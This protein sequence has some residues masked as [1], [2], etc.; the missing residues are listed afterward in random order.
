M[1]TTNLIVEFLVIGIQ[2]AVWISLLIL[3][4][5]GTNWLEFG[6]VKEFSTIIVG[7]LIAI[8]YPIGVFVDNF[9]DRILKKKD[10]KI[11]NEFIK[12]ENKSILRV[13]TLAGENSPLDQLFN[14]QRMRIRISRSSFLNFL[15]ISL[16]LPIFFI[17]QLPKY[18]G[19]NLVWVCL[20]TSAIG[21]GF[22]YL[23]YW[24]WK[25]V[26]KRYYRRYP[27]AE[28]LLKERGLLK[29]SKDKSEK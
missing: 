27:E 9:A 10:K 12:D 11:R 1:N 28:E 15:I 14:Y 24:T 13:R 26:S 3:T 8:S 16:M 25:D 23:A 21:I 6:K 4:F 20:L 18:F 17:I 19:S 5:T 29:V 7:L 2:V 22:T